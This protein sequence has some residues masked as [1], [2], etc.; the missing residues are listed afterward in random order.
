MKGSSAKDRREHLRVAIALYKVE[1]GKLKLARVALEENLARERREAREW[2]RNRGVGFLLRV[3]C[4]ETMAGI[5]RKSGLSGGRVNQIVHSAFWR[6][7]RCLYRRFR[8]SGC[9]DL[10]RWLRENRWLFRK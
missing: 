2:S 1:I 7:Y 4:G 10:S 5:A 9:G 6:E 8:E 3:V